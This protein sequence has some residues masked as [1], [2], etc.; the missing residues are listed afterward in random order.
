MF[1]FKYK[2]FSVFNRELHGA[3][4]RDTSE[5]PTS[6]AFPEAGDF[7]TMRIGTFRAFLPQVHRLAIGDRP[8]LPGFAPL[9]LH[10]NFKNQQISVKIPRKRHLGIDISVRLRKIDINQGDRSPELSSDSLS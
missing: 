10:Q 3:G 8:S 4:C 1:S 6:L 5:T 2:L 9:S 7:P